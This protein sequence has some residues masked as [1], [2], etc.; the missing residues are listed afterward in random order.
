MWP[1]GL[2]WQHVTL[3]LT[4]A[5]YALRTPVIYNQMQQSTVTWL[6]ASTLW[7]CSVTDRKMKS[8][9]KIHRGIVWLWQQHFL[10]EEWGKTEALWEGWGGGHCQKQSGAE[11]EAIDQAKLLCLSIWASLTGVEWH[12]IGKAIFIRLCLRAKGTVGTWA[13]VHICT[14]G[15]S[16]TD[17]LLDR[18]AP[19]ACVQTTHACWIRGKIQ[20]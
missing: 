14:R 17:G 8:N 16:R 1:S 4:A 7:D 19:N 2:S 3:L 5:H 11:K 6:P 20:R 13:C 10:L 18:N 15:E 9:E 12:K